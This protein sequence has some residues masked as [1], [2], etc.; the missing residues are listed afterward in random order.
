MPRYVG[1]YNYNK[2]IILGEGGLLREKSSIAQLK[3]M[4]Q[5]Q[6]AYKIAKSNVGF[7]AIMTRICFLKK[8]DK[9]VGLFILKDAKAIEEA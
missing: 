5:V 9:K 7:M 4:V 3:V 2:F 1:T 8:K 6:T